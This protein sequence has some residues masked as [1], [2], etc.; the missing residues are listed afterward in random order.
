MS[1]AGCPDSYKAYSLEDFVDVNASLVPPKDLFIE[2]DVVRECGGV[3][4][5]HGVVDVHS[6]R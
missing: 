2:V 1:V 6:F 3:Q 4:T 5:E